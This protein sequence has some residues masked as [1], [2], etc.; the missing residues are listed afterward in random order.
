MSLFVTCAQGLEPLLLE[1]LHELGVKG[2]RPGFRGVYVDDFCME[3]IYRIN[4]CSRIASRVLCPIVRFRCRQKEALYH[5]V[6]GVDWKR[7]FRKGT[8]FAIDAN[9]H[10]PEL[11]HSLFA[12]QVA[13]DAI[14]DE[15]RKTLGT[16]PD[17]DLKAP[18]LQLNLFIHNY[19][20]VLSFDTSG[21]ALHKRGYRQEAGDAP[22]QE[23]LAAALL[24]IARFQGQ[25]RIIDPCCGSGTL[26][27]EAALIA[28]KTA[29]GYLRKVW[30]FMRHPEFSQM[31]WLKVKN[32]ADAARIPL[33]GKKI[34]G[35]EIDSD[36]ARICRG[37]LRAAGVL[38]GVDILRVDFAEH[39]PVEAP[40]FLIS[41]PPYGNRMMDV[42]PNVAS[43]GQLYRQLGHFMKQKLAKPSRA[44]LFIGNLELTK[45]VGL[46]A[47]RR[48]VLLN[49]G[50]D[51]RLL[52][53]DLY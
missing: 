43:L 32:E 48:H 9:V 36:M 15:L 41:N 11:R 8:T 44:F 37:N 26:L 24:R 21:Q 6:A 19:Q 35:C 53:F 50:I 18:D 31:E 14:C 10:H 2:C 33:E 13:K 20:G 28:S 17:V 22:L 29:P 45:E 16:R 47:K 40:D 38:D 46:A 30:G 51:S 49:G 3:T 52:E 34:I 7:Y 25:E 4:Y 42:A 12:A 5:A 39:T 27:I 23:S 1:E